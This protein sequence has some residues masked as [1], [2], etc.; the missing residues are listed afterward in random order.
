MSD[1]RCLIIRFRTC[2]F[3]VGFRGIVT[4]GDIIPDMSCHGI[5][6]RQNIRTC[7]FQSSA[8]CSVAGWQEARLIFRRSQAFIIFSRYILDGLSSLCSQALNGS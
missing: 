2:L 6:R 5:G 4:G 8:V 3:D 7:L 1:S